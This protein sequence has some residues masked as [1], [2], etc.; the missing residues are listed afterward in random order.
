MI[1]IKFKLQ[2]VIHIL[3][4]LQWELSR[5]NITQTPVPVIICSRRAMHHIQMRHANERDLTHVLADIPH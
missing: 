1:L 4:I 2:S 5:E 3:F